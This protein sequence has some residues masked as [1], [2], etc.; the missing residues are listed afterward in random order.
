MSFLTDLFEGHTDKLGTDLSHAGS[1]LMNHPTEMLEVGGAAALGA[2]PFLLPELLGGAGAGIGGLGEMFGGGAAAAGADVLPEAAA[3][4]EG[5]G[6]VG[7]TAVADLLGGAGGA[8]AQGADVGGLFGS[9][10]GNTS[11]AGGLGTTGEVA[12]I[13][14]STVLDPTA[15]AGAP[16]TT[17]PMAPTPGGGLWD[18]ATG[19]L[20]GLGV[21][22]MQA[23]GAA[24][25]AG[26]LAYNMMQGQKPLAD[27]AALQGQATQLSAQGQQF[28]KYLQQG[29]LP[30]GM[31]LL[32]DKQTNAAKAM[33]ISNAAK[34][35][36]STDPTTNTQL[37]DAIN[38]ANQQ[39]T[40]QV[41][42]M[43]EMLFKQGLSETQVSAQIMEYLTK[44]DE[45][46]TQNMGMAIMNFASALSG[47]PMRKAA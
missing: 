23:A 24:V 44:L 30:K 18:S 21:T 5:G 13:A 4:T 27:Q 22:P 38:A 26:G 31:Q 11:G 19:A 45:Q 1:S 47:G 10:F 20:K 17:G 46:Q 7:N 6:M 41:A 36:Q 42:Q 37:A 40:M 28:M 3:L 2:A 34:N 35:G 43:G 32:V 14:S 8:P 16:A 33:A 39:A 9:M 25:G 12:P 15:L 29:K